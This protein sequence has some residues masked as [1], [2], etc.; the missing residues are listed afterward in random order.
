MTEEIQTPEVEKQEVESRA[1]RTRDRKAYVPRVDIFETEDHITL[2]TD[3]PGVDENSVEITLEKNLLTINGLVEAHTPDNYNLV[4]A[5][6]EVGDYERSFTLSNQI[7]QDN[8]QA[9]VKSGVLHL[10]LPKVGPTK[11]RKVAVKAG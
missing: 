10:R 3:M 7:D 5:E 4:Y 2:V 8:I 1:E 11:A 9:A 6:Y